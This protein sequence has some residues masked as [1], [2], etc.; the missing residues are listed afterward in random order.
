MCLLAITQY[1]GLSWRGSSCVPS[2]VQPQL[3]VCSQPSK[4]LIQ[5]SGN[6]LVSYVTQHHLPIYKEFA[7]A[8]VIKM[9]LF[10]AGNRDASLVA[11]TWVRKIPGGGHGYPLQCPCLENP[12]DRAAWRATVHRVTKDSHFHT[13]T[14]YQCWGRLP[15]GREFLSAT[16]NPSLAVELTGG[17]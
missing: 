5:L 2:S 8:C 1:P 3:S 11:Q 13:F 14:F 12:M 4:Q 7:S 10:H 6:K 17:D 15:G 16:P 9:L